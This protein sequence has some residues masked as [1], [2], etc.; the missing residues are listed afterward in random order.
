MR[1]PRVTGEHIAEGVIVDNVGPSAMF[2]DDLSGT[3]EVAALSFD[4]LQTSWL[5][6]NDWFR[7]WL[8]GLELRAWC[9]RR[10]SR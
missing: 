5:S 3:V 1:P 8:A 10:C 9:S 4:L 6:V 7:A 2:L